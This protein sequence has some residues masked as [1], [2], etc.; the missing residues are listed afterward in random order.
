MK[1]A[2]KS[3]FTMKAVTGMT[4]RQFEM[5][6][7][8]FEKAYM[9]YRREKYVRE[10]HQRGMGGGNKPRLRTGAEKLFFIL[11]YYKCYPTFGVM[12]VLFDLDAGKCCRWVH[13]LAPILEQVLK[14]KLV[15]PKRKIRSLE[16]FI[17]V[18]P[19]IQEAF[20]DGTERPIRRPQD[21]D[22]QKENYSGKKK[23]HTKKNVVITDRNKKIMLVSDTHEGKKHDFSILKEEELPKNIPKWIELLL[24]T[25]FEGIEKLYPDHKVLKPKKKPHKKTLSPVMKK[26]NKAIAQKRIIV[27][28]A[29][30]GIKRYNVVSHV[31]RNIKEGFDDLVMISSAGLWNYYLETR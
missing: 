22:K 5:L 13:K 14:Q 1:R 15:L 18:F 20:I 31:Y 11:F 17:K 21:S 4:V 7:Y 19:E 16:E 23:R 12:E 3:D 9:R 29:I 24:D 30:G 27:E 25:G 28:N 10:K 2:F 26:R 6:A 8:E